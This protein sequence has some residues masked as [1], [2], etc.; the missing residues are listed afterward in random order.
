MSS[1]EASLVG[2]EGPAN[3]RKVDRLGPIVTCGRLHDDELRG[4][5]GT[6]TAFGALGCLVVRQDTK[7]Q[8][9]DVRRLADDDRFGEK[10]R[11]GRHQSLSCPRRRR[12]HQFV[13]WA[14]RGCDTWPW[15]LERP[16]PV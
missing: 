2:V 6:P 13:P 11:C 7:P 14:S 8:D 4:L 3:P 16:C 1:P 12:R 15:A 10:G 9:A 5:S